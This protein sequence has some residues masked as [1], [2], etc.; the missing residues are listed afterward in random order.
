MGVQSFSTLQMGPSF[1]WTSRTEAHLRSL[2]GAFQV[3]TAA[4]VKDARHTVAGIYSGKVKLPCE[5]KLSKL[6]E[7]A[8][9]ACDLM[10]SECFDIVN[11][12]FIAQCC[13][14]WSWL[15]SRWHWF[16]SESRC[17][18]LS[19]FSPSRGELFSLLF[20]C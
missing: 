8:N 20:G 17:R 14:T 7:A 18:M 10:I 9:F 11:C 19:Q 16:F 5:S 4:A 3:C 13:L 6:S 2:A 12:A 1:V 15:D